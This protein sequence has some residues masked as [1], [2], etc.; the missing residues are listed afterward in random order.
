MME[1]EMEEEIVFIKLLQNILQTQT[2]RIQAAR[3]NY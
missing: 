3:I 1:K 2:K